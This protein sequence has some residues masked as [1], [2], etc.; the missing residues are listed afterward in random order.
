MINKTILESIPRKSKD[1]L[2]STKVD[3]LKGTKIVLIEY[4][5]TLEISRWPLYKLTLK[6]G[7]YVMLLYNLNPT[8]CLYNRI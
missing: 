6:V 5:N 3:D 2:S 4:M 7:T 8:N 1:V